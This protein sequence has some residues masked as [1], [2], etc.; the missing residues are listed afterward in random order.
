MFYQNLTA[1]DDTWFRQPTIY[2]LTG[3]TLHLSV[4]A[5][6]LESNTGAGK[7]SRIS[8]E[9]TTDT[10]TAFASPTITVPATQ[11]VAYNIWKK[12]FFSVYI[13]VGE[14]FAKFA[15]KFTE[16]AGGGLGAYFT[17]VAAYQPY[18]DTGWSTSL[19]GFAAGANW[20]LQ[21]GLWRIRDNI[22]SIR[23]VYQRTTSVLAVP[24][25][26]NIG[27]ITVVTTP[28]ALTPVF[29]QGLPAYGN[30]PLMAHNISSSG[31]GLTALAPGG[32]IAIGDNL[33]F[34]GSYFLDG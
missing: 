23:V 14:L 1:G 32:N 17:Q 34:S 6:G 5:F 2:P 29:A 10:T 3:Q 12:Y 33:S 16:A 24:A 15:V 13:P 28:A 22:A 26:G 30:G 19:T 9:V 18:D 27:N 7:D 8:I 21:S 25:D 31:V 11:R 4:W 20:S